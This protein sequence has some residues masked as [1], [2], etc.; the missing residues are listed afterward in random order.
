[1]TTTTR[2]PLRTAQETATSTLHVTPTRSS[3]PVSV[4]R[5]IPLA[6]IVGV[7]LRKSFDTRS[8]MWLLASIGLAALLTTGAI[9]AWAPREQLA[10]SQFVL[11]IGMPMSVI[12]PII[13][14]LSV[15]AEW[16]QRTG[17]A[18]FTLV[19]HRGR[20]LL[21][22]ALASMLVAAASTVVTFVVAALGNVVAA[23]IAGI[24]PVWDGDATALVSFAAAIALLLLTGFTLGALIRNSA[25]AVVA[26]MIYAFVAPG[27]LA[28]L[29]MS[30]SWFR[31][32]RPWVDAK[33]T[34]DALMNGGLV[35]DQWMHLAVTTVVW[36]A[37]PL[38][39]GV[40]TVLRSEVK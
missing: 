24:A 28:L 2:A 31:D 29:A 37:L 35:G 8:G 38:T 16:T 12:L 13:A 1:M 26:Y 7:E 4:P 30:Q 14:A 21:A 3:V 23:Q 15:T 33:Y 40:L 9:I 19:P 5:P 25:G 10:Y 36:L 22:K 39:A 11:A 20:V 34:Q 18:T 6:R 32:I 27:A 17:L